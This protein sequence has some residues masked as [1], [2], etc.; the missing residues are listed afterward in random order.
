[1][2]A[3]ANLQNLYEAVAFNKMF[4]EKNNPGA[5]VYADKAKKYYLNDSLLSVQYNELNN[6]K[7][8][9]IMDQTHI[10]YTY[11]Q[12]PDKQVMPEVKY[13]NKEPIKIRDSSKL[14]HIIVT[15]SILELIIE[16]TKE[17][18]NKNL[19]VEHDGYVSIE[20]A[21]YTTKK[22]AANIHWK[23]IPNIGKDGDGVTTFPV[24]ASTQTINA[25]TPHLEYDF[26]TYES[27]SFKVN[28]YFSPTLNFTGDSTGLQYAVSIDDE[29]PQIISINKDDHNTKPWSEWVANNIIIKTTNHSINKDGKHAIKY[30][31]ISP[32]VILQKIVIDFG[33]L[34][35]SYLGPQETIFKSGNN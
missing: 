1:M 4:Y 23:I 27:G 20:A 19:F 7:W 2:K 17:N 30:W 21:H 9:H 28:A 22:D 8:N 11:W 31:M 26:Y 25:N 14:K 34:E 5:N 3:Y 15:D 32:A 33:G 29:Q 10:G 18:I 35:P 12:Q 16:P 6:G 13:I 24:T